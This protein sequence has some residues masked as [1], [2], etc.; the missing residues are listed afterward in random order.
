MASVYALSSSVDLTA[1]STPIG[2]ITPVAITSTLFTAT[3][4]NNTS[5]LVT[6]TANSLTG[7]NA[8][9]LVDLAQTWNTS[10]APTLIKADVTNLAS[11]SASLIDLQVGGVSHFSVHS[12]GTLSG[13]FSGYVGVNGYASYVTTGAS[14]AGF[15]GGSS[16]AGL[17]LGAAY[18]AVFRREAANTLAQRNGVN[19]QIQN[20]YKSFTDASN[21]TR[22]A[23][24]FN[25]SGVQITG[26]SA[27]TGDANISVTLTT[28][29]TGSIRTNGKIYPAT[30]AG[31]EQTAAGIYG[32]TGAPSNANGANGD[33]YLRS[34]GS[35]LTTV[36]QRRAGTW[37]GIV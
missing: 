21:Y 34:D 12:N 8:Q 22:S 9:S 30:D 20:L 33:F 27:G 5:A 35:A 18:D 25:A 3:P 28:K 13:P 24:L 4:A 10:G 19:S 26:E 17:F 31:A 16:T 32:G 6:G 14:D 36:Y 15:Y 7:S 37:T 29:G 2:S 23:W 1:P 11:V